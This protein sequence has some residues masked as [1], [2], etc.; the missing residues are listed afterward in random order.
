MGNSAKF[1]PGD[2]VYHIDLDNQVRFGCVSCVVP[3]NENNYPNAPIYEVD[4][5]GYIPGFKSL[6]FYQSEL[7]FA[8]PD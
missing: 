5:L 4:M 7:E 3:V 1:K 6:L 2:S 8:S